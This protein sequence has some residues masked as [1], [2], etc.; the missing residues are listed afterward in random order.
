MID[1]RR[2]SSVLFACFM[3]VSSLFAIEPL[4]PL[5]TATSPI[6]D[7]KLDDE[8]WSNAPSVSGFETFIPYFGRTVPEQTTVL[9][10]YDAENLYFAFK[11]IDPEPSKIKTSLSPRDKIIADDW[12]CINLDSF[13]DQQGLYAFYIN[14]AGIQAESKFAAG[15]EDFSLDVVWYSA[16]MLTPTGYNIEVQIPLKS[17]RYSDKNPT[18]MSVFFERYVSRKTEHS[19]YPHL[20]PNKGYAFLTQMA[21]MEYYDLRHYTLFELL[22]AWTYSHKSADTEGKLR[23]TDNKGEASLSA[24]YGITSDLILDATYNPDFSQVEADAGQVDV[25]LRYQ[26]FFAEKRPFFLEGQ[27]IFTVAATSSSELDP[28]SAVIHTRT[29]VDPLVGVKL[30]GKVGD[31]NTLSVLY[32]MDTL[33]PGDP[34]GKDAHVPIVRY[35][36]ALSEDSFV[37]GIAASR[38]LKNGYNRLGGID[39][40]IRIGSATT[41]DFHGLLSRTST[42]DPG[43]QGNGHAV[44][45]KYAYD[46]QG[47]D[48]SLSLEEI[49]EQFR[50]DMGYVTR[51]GIFMGTARFHPKFY[52][53]SKV[54]R[55][56]D[57]EGFSGQTKDRPSGLWETYNRGTVTLMFMNALTARFNGVY[58]TEVFAGRRFKTSGGSTTVSG[59]LTKWLSISL[60]YRQGKAIF[61]SA[62]P[63]QGHN[64]TLSA[65]AAVQPSEQLRA[66]L[67][68]TYVK[69]FRDSDGLKIYEYPISRAKLT[70]QFNKYFFF[71]GIAEYNNYRKQ[72]LTDLLA[73]FTYIP[74][75]VVYLGY[76]SIYKK[77]RWETNAYVDDPNFLELQRG[78]FFKMSY[79]WRS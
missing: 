37:G 68:F 21:P 18:V 65:T 42:N 78:I 50:L 32:A 54:F 26:L 12:V 41:F 72:L 58:S 69:F 48:Y 39:G 56:I 44:G 55:R 52:P 51:S 20:D 63:Y 30:S 27:D 10:A 34:S 67:S 75:T 61:F 79:L 14:P 60:L 1:V 74:G 36:R 57:L 46:T 73:S 22:P 24:K 62:N 31:D 43:P 25:N 8:I 45:L 28:V 71:R 40:S 47:L 4:R 23:T 17:I 19:S 15:K 53:T 38:E 13:N 3:L 11:C 5:R 77:T 49:S 76:G 35:K 29:I 66:D 7:G 70:Y 6:I 2:A 33:P 9:M 16:G 64:S 59:L